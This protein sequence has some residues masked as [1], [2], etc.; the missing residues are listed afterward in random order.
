[1]AKIRFTIA[2]LAASAI[3]IPAFAL[4]QTPRPGD[5][6]GVLRMSDNFTHGAEQTVAKTV[7]T[8]LRRELRGLGFDAFD[9]RL[10]FEELSRRSSPTPDYFVEIVSSHSMNHPVGGAAIGTGDFAV[11]VGIVVAEVAAEVRLY[12]GRTLN[13]IA[14]YDL[15]KKN[16]AVLPMGIGIGGRPLFAW[17]V[18]PF[19][20]YGQY[21]AA[22]HEVARQAAQ[23]IA[24]Q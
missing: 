24:G 23:R 15:H 13:Q 9:T 20:Q 4:T 22:A 11:D 10:T 1:M 5:R 8:D 6:I 18:L 2:L 19:V 3:A 7:Q 16:T 14:R 12:D 21:R 17:F